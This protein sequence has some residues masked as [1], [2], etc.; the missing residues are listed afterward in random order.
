MQRPCGRKELI[1]FKE[2]KK[3][4]ECEGGVV[5]LSEELNSILRVMERHK[6]ALIDCSLSQ[7]DTYS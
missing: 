5:G 3:S 1:L 6:C 2:L 7:K 4:V